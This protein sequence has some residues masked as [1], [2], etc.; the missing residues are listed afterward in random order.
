MVN[1]KYNQRENMIELIK[2]A[3]CYQPGF[4]KIVGAKEIEN[5]ADLIMYF[6]R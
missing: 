2:G 5:I 4:A 1:T 3:I 6:E